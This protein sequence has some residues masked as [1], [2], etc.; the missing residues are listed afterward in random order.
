M[1]ASAGIGTLD[2]SPKRTLVAG[3]AGFIGGR[4]TGLRIEDDHEV[5]VI[6]G[7]SRGRIENPA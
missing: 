4:L 6:D 7:F 5:V 1:D 3:G 2:R